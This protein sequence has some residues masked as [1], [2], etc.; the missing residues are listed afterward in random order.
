MIY[1]ASPYT[2]TVI[3]CGNGASKELAAPQRRS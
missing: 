1:L 2:T 3:S